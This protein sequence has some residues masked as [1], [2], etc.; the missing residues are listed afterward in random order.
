MHIFLLIH[1]TDPIYKVTVK[2]QSRR[3]YPSLTHLHCFMAMVPQHYR[4]E[5]LYAPASYLSFLY[6]FLS[7]HYFSSTFI[8]L[9]YL[10]FSFRSLIY[11]V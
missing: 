6:I 8:S 10:Y 9:P 5:S 11:G 3:R 4:I 2:S 7:Y 1:N